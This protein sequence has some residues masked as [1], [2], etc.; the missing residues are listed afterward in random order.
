[1]VPELE[2]AL[3]DAVPG[4]PPDVDHVVGVQHAE[5]LLSGG[6]T[7]YPER[8]RVRNNIH[9]FFGAPQ[10]IEQNYFAVF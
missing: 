5:F 8:W 2:L 6:Q 9:S 3:P 7:F 1:M 10:A 4:T